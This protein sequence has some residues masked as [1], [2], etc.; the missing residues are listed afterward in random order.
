[1]AYGDGGGLFPSIVPLILD[2]DFLESNYIAIVEPCGLHSG[3]EDHFIRPLHLASIKYSININ[4]LYEVRDPNFI[5]IRDFNMIM[6][7]NCSS[8]QKITD[9]GV[10]S[11]IQKNEATKN[12]SVLI[13]FELC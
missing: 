4:Y 1:M 5:G 8:V 10:S 6:E 12:R 2:S 13:C 9:I 3:V 7:L 11:Y